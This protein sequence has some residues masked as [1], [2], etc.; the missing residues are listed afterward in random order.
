MSEER[1]FMARLVD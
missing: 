1:Y